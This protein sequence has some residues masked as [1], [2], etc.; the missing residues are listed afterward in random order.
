MR[1]LCFLVCV[2][3]H[4][5]LIETLQPETLREFE[6]YQA[7]IDRELQER[8]RGDRPFQWI[9]EHPD[10]RRE[11]AEGEIVTYAIAGTNGRNVTD[12][13]V[14]DWV[15]SMLLKGSRLDAVRKFLL[16]TGQHA[17]VYPD[18]QAARILSRSPNGSVTLLRIEKKKVLRVVLDIEYVNEWEQPASM[19][20]V[21]IARSR[22]ITEIDGDKPL[23]LDTGHGF[24]WRMNSQWS[25]R[26]DPAGVW[27]ELRSVSLSRDTPRAFAWIVRPL[28]RNFPSE[29]LLSTLKATREAVKSQ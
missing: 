27:V 23:P 16:D 21:M 15:G 26:E 7:V 28:V 22:R 17:H 14:H 25:L 18:V 4:A 11:V 6:R 19:R 8:V 24:L 2:L 5:Q 3:G 1:Y 10:K 9:D 20:W 29:A 13:L 12:G